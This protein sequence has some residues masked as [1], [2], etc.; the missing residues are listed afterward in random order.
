MKFNISSLLIVCIIV[1]TVG[2][3]AWFTMHTIPDPI[4]D[5]PASAVIAEKK[6][7]IPPPEGF[8]LAEGNDLDGTWHADASSTGV[9]DVITI[10]VIGNYTATLGEEKAD[11]GFWYMENNTLSFFS[12]KKK[13]LNRVFSHVFISEDG[14]TLHLIK[15]NKTDIWKKQE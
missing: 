14:T 8:R 9:Y 3:L 13:S 11:E 7:N 4:S 12:E 1:L 2:V 6:E 10:S 5:N 15:G